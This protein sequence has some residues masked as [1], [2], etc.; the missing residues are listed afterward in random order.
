[1]AGNLAVSWNPYTSKCSISEFTD[2]ALLSEILILSCSF[3]LCVA[4]C[5]K[6]WDVGLGLGYL[7]GWSMC[8]MF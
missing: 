1:M 4:V 5:I 8:S 6:K 7:W 2:K 3:F